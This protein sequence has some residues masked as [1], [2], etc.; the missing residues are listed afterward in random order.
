[1]VPVKEVMMDP[2]LLLGIDRRGGVFFVAIYPLEKGGALHDHAL[3]VPHQALSAPGKP[4]S[5]ARKLSMLY[6]CIYIYIYINTPIRQERMER[7]SCFP[8]HS[9]SRKLLFPMT[10]VYIDHYIMEKML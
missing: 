1:M 8:H 4:P 2:L 3:C 10:R 7:G 9:L 6:I 5:L